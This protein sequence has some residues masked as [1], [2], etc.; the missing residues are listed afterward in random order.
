MTSNAAIVGGQRPLPRFFGR[1]SLALVLGLYTVY[2]LGPFLWLATMSVR[3]TAEIS[4][5]P[6]GWPETFRWGQFYSAWVDANFASYFLNS[7]IVV[8]GAVVIVTLIGAA[9]A[10]AL[11]RYRFRGNRLIYAILFSSIIFPPQIT[12]ISL[13]QILVDYNLYN[14]LLGLTLVYISLQL[15]LTVY[16]LEGFFARIPQDLF[17]AAK[18][19]GYGDLEI[20]WRIVLPV[21]MPAIATTLILNFI[22]LWNE[23]LFAVVLVTDPDKRTLPI[24]LRAFMGDNFQDIGMIAAGVMVSVIPVIV[25]YMF[26]SEKLIRGMTAGA[27]K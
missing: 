22:Q 4:A 16:L 12:L 1:G 14:S 8:V 5:D 2:T 18:M 6:Y 11:A 23:F 25:A 26:F 17:D 27:I 13:Y 24:G 15:P 9:A 21:G 7:T 10:H 19:D 20:F 3:S